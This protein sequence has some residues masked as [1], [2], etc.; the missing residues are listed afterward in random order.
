LGD[1]SRPARKANNLTA[2]CVPTVK[3]MRDSQY[4]TT[5]WASTA[6]YRK[7]FAFRFAFSS[8]SDLI[9]YAASRK[10]TGSSPDEATELLILHN[11]SSRTMALGFT[12]PL[13]ET[14]T[15]NLPRR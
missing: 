13:A 12:Q 9:R 3:K 7:I 8:E 14:S 1:N 4:L 10:V 5:L 2:I 11:P 15:R 6:C